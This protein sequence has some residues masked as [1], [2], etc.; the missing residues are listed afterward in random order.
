MSISALT[1]KID[2]FC[3][4]QFFNSET[5]KELFCPCLKKLFKIFGP[6]HMSGWGNLACLSE[7]ESELL[8]VIRPTDNHT[9]GPVIREVSP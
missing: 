7:S 1:E 5:I 9:P 8:L 6:G 3:W 4:V 2:T